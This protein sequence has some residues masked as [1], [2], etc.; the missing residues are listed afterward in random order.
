MTENLSLDYLK[1][2]ENPYPNDKNQKTG[3]PFLALFL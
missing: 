1:E 2:K 3:A